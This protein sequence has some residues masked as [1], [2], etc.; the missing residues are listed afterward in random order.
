MT[1]S[2]AANTIRELAPLLIVAKIEDSLRF[3]REQLGFHMIEAW[4]P[5]GKIGW[6]RLE[7]DGVRLMLQQATDEDGPAVGRGHGVCF[8]FQ[9]VDA[10]AEYATLCDKGL[11]LQEPTIAFFGM[12][13]LFVTDPDGYE[14]CFQTPVER[15]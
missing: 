12:K 3:Y 14:L 11:S 6:C 1:A 2:L 4:V 5:D 15:T 10:D 13:Q 8:F 9:C 7:R